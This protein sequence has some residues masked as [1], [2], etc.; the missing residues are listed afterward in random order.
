MTEFIEKN[1]HRGWTNL[2]DFRGIRR[3]RIVPHSQIRRPDEIE[4]H[5]G[6]EAEGY[7]APQP[8]TAGV[9]KG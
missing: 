7:A 5:G 3:D 4:Y 6:Y 8:E 1:A 9:A 2:E